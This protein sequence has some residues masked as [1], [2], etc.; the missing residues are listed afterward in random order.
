MARTLDFCYRST[1]F[2]PAIS[3]IV[4]RSHEQEVLQ[5]I[6]TCDAVKQCR[7]TIVHMS[8]VSW[9]DLLISAGFLVSA[10]ESELF[11]VLRVSW[12]FVSLQWL[13]QG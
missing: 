13:Q 12:L 2:D 7:F 1:C 5:T 11:H 6:L 10:S 8:V 4:T 9:R 3:A